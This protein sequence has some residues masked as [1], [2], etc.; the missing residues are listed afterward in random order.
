M[1]SVFCL[2]LQGCT[3]YLYL[4]YNFFGNA[5]SPAISRDGGS[6]AARPCLQGL[7]N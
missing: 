2:Q 4:G 7:R 6:P 3:V 5:L 1:V